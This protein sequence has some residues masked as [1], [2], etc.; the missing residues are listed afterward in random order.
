MR[1]RII[2]FLT[3]AIVAVGVA[4]GAYFA[5]QLS[6]GTTGAQEGPER[7]FPIPTDVPAEAQLPV[8]AADIQQGPDGKLFVPD[9]GDGCPYHEVMR[10]T[11]EG[12]EWVL[13]GNTTCEMYWRYAPD[14]GEVAAVT[15]IRSDI[16]TAEAPSDYGGPTPTPPP[17]ASPTPKPGRSLAAPAAYIKLDPD[18]KY[19]RPDVGDGC[20]YR[21][22]SRWVEERQEWILLQSPTCDPDLLFAPATSDV[23]AVVPSLP[24]PVPPATA[25]PTATAPVQGVPRL[26]KP[27]PS[28]IKTGPDGKYYIPERGD[29]CPWAESG[30]FP[31]PDGTLK[32]L[33]ETECSPN[34]G[35]WYFPE[36]GE[37]ILVVS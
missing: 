37:I 26:D 15:V 23:R 13:F 21:E 18:G 4:V 17:F 31:Q 28:E 6:D 20:V 22:A 34:L 33:L 32:I 12:R 8:E 10:D 19:F 24:T 11:F 14:T 30:R 5:T 1:S 27:L 29:G 16:S 7:A 2:G 35:F 25:E 36:T 3:F 9:R